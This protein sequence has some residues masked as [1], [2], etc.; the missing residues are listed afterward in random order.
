MRYV[1]IQIRISVPFLTILKKK[2]K[3]GPRGCL[4]LTGDGF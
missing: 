2:I 1:K 4:Q 3:A